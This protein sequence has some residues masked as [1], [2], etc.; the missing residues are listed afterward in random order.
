MHG[1]ITNV[2]DSDLRLL[3]QLVN[4]DYPV[5]Y[6]RPFPS[7]GTV[8]AGACMSWKRSL[9]SEAKAVCATVKAA[10]ILPAPLEALS[11]HFETR[12]SSAA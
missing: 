9:R 10:A 12:D 11:N 5:Q 4:A 1:A 6:D 7:A 8:R 3:T 2:Y